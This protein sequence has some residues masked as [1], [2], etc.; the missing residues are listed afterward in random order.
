MR[1][2]S[3]SI[4]LLNPPKPTL[5]EVFTVNGGLD[6]MCAAGQILV[7]EDQLGRVLEILGLPSGTEGEPVIEG[8][9]CST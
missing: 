1:H 8:V 2:V 5:I 7:R 3:L 4:P 9:V 6:F